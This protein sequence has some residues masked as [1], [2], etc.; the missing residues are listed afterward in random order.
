MFRALQAPLRQTGLAT[1]AS[2]RTGILLA[3]SRSFSLSTSRLYEHIIVGNP[4]PSVV[5]ITL[6]RPK[7][8]NAL[9]SALFHEI[10]EATQAADEDDSIGAIVLTGSEKAF[11]A[12]ADI[13]EMKDK[14]FAS[15]YK[16]NF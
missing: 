9:N 5:Q 12:G 4:K 1:A 11:A 15:A 16:S 7:A 2:R 10:N 13:K 8:L 3:S 6:N 14:E